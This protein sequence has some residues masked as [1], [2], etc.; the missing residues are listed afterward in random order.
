MRRD[1]SMFMKKGERA[2][3]KSTNGFILFPDDG[4]LITDEFVTVTGRS[5]ENNE[6]VYSTISDSGIESIQKEINLIPEFPLDRKMYKNKN[7]KYEQ[8]MLDSL[9]G[10]W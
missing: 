9:D 4:P 6:R 1:G 2:R 3:L 8:E 7:T 10:N 5:S